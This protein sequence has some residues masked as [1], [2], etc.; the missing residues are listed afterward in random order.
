MAIKTTQK[1][2]LGALLMSLGLSVANAESDRGGRDYDKDRGYERSE[3]GYDDDRRYRERE[4][5]YRRYG[6]KDEGYAMGYQQRWRKE[7]TPE[8]RS[9]LQNKDDMLRQE[10]QKLRTQIR[11]MERETRRMMLQDNPDMNA[12]EARIREANNLRV[13]QRMMHMRHMVEVRK[14]L[15]E[16]QRKQFDDEMMEGVA[17]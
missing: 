16:K 13:Q 4:E 7:L 5:D 1:L 12:V 6:N 15:N 8:Q 9:Q 10:Q 2:L 17:E 14:M 3:R 11:D